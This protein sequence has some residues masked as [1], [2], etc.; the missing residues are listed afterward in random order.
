MGLGAVALAWT[1]MAAAALSDPTPAE[2]ARARPTRRQ[3]EAYIDAAAAQ[4]GVKRELVW[5]V[6]QA[7][8]SFDHDVVSPSGAVGLMQLMPATAE[9]FG[10][11]D[12]LDARQNIFAGTRYLKRLLDTYAGDVSLSAAAYN[13]GETAVARFKGIPPYRAT[14]AY[15]RRVTTLLDDLLPDEAPPAGLYSVEMTVVPCPALGWSA[16][17]GWPLAGCPALAGLHRP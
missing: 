4:H 8:S 15:V 10:A 16:A 9:R 12:P 2:P 7:E 11:A 5:A 3:L 13:A 1:L 17:L 6:I 14:R